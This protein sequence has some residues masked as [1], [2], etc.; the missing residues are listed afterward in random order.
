MELQQLG[1]AKPADAG[2]YLARVTTLLDEIQAHLRRFAHELRP[3]MLDDLGLMPALEALGQ[4]V[5]SRSGIA[6]SIEGSTEGRLAP[7]V[8]I[9]LYRT[10]QEALTN[11][12]KHSG[13]ARAEVSVER[14]R[15]EV[16]CTVTDDGVGFAPATS[17][18]HGLGLIGLRERLA[19]LGGSVRW[20]SIPGVGGAVL[21]VTI[22]VEASHAASSPN[23]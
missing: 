8:E 4:S 13:A 22:P 6:V 23:S 17:H 14:Q 18:N 20:G 12:T 2:P 10:V 3:T 15:G 7:A 5:S 21:A 11:T 9:A 16:R 19:S 1:A